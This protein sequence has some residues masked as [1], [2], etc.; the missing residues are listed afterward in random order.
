MDWSQIAEQIA[1]A[2]GTPFA[3][4][5][6]RS[7][8]G[9]CINSAYQLDDGERAYFV[10]INRGE[11]LSMFEAEAAGLAELAAAGGPRVPQPLCTGVADCDAF[12]AM[13][14]IDLGRQRGDSAAEAG[15]QL[16]R[17]HRCTRETFGWDRENT[18]GS[19]PQPNSPNADWIAFWREQRLGF[20]LELAAR[21]GHGGRLQERGARLME[22]LPALLDHAPAPSLLHGDL[23][24][25][26]IGYDRDG[27]PIIFD[28]AVYF[29]DR[30]AD[31]AMTELFGGFGGDFHAA[32]REAWPL[33][34]GY[35]T[36]KSLYNLYHILN[37]LN[38][39][40]SG[41]LSQ[42]EGLIDRLLSETRG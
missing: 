3:P 19:T 35:S 17:M 4:S 32:Y 6:P 13:E 33:P 29:G 25:G 11:T 30:E 36:R 9:G 14:W 12:I 37:H 1:A 23:W 10:K 39:F 41:Y 18:I 5:A 2:S 40:G 28:P 27:T 38:L 34:P 31:L 42:A 22:A 16:A 24:G 26:N 21:H 15:R 20:Q 7:I 8:G